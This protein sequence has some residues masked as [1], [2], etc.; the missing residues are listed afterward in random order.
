[1]DFAA[2][3]LP[4]GTTFY[5]PNLTWPNH[6]TIAKYAG[7]GLKHYAYYDAST[8]SANISTMLRDLKA[9]NDGDIVCLHVCAHNPTGCDLSNSEWDQVLETVKAKKTHPIHGYGLPRIHIRKC[10]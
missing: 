10:R 9:A 7:L 2:Q 4:K 8:K 1:M 5:T 3:F 6:N